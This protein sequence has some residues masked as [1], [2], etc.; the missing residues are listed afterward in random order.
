MSENSRGK[1]NL[2]AKWGN[3]V[4]D[5][6]V[7]NIPS[8]VSLYGMK[9]LNG[10][11]FAFVMNIFS[12]KYSSGNPFPARETIAENMGKNIRQVDRWIS[13]L[14]EK[15][16]MEVYHRYKDGKRTSSEYEFSGLLQKCLAESKKKRAEKEKGI[17]RV[18]KK[19]KSAENPDIKGKKLTVHFV[20]EEENKLP[21]QNVQLGHAKMYRKV[22]PK[23]TSRSCQNVQGNKV[24]FKKEIL[25]KGIINN[26]CVP[27]Y[28]IQSF[29]NKNDRSDLKKHTQKIYNLYLKLKKKKYFKMNVFINTLDIIDLDIKNFSY[30]E[31][32]MINNIKKGFV[33]KYDV[34]EQTESKPSYKPNGENQRVEQLPKWMKEKKEEKPQQDDDD[35]EEQKR[36][37]E[38]RL[39]KYKQ[40]KS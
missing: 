39:K 32:A 24:M 12:Y 22:M 37:L 27:I 40:N 7:M 14:E 26:V 33:K 36:Q 28:E 1:E 29:I 21:V 2:I 3:E 8:C 6:G 34:Q 35:F 15:G 25:N 17:K 9:F 38:E 13:S 19:K 18:K 4:F 30:L 10:G 23:C 31:N 5:D 16:L 20:Q 11:E